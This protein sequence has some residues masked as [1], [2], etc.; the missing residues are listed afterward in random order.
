MTY[1]TPTPR[2]PQPAAR[3][4][5]PSCTASATTQLPPHSGTNISSPARTPQSRSISNRSVAHPKPAR[6]SSRTTGCFFRA[7]LSVPTRSLHVL[8][9][10]ARTRGVAQ[11]AR[12]HPVSAR[13]GTNP[14]PRHR[15]IACPVG[16][17]TTFVSDRHRTK[18]LRSGEV[19]RRNRECPLPTLRGCAQSLIGARYGAY[20]L[21][22]STYQQV[23]QIGRYGVRDVPPCR[24][25][26]F[27][28][29]R[30]IGHM[31]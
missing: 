14:A 30:H 20:V 3:R 2:S 7:V 24:F 16:N 19:A 6:R 8:T 10:G 12:V 11:W 13:L 29:T 26:R 9:C 1:A 25:F 21:L 28:R 27:K 31:G 5:A 22:R 15:A 18:P 17:V 4:C 23:R